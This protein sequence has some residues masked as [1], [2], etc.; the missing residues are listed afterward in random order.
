MA[1]NHRWLSWLAAV[2]PSYHTP[3]RAILAQALWTSALVATGSYRALFTR[4]VYTEWIFFALMAMGLMAAR[5]RSDYRPGVRASGYPVVPLLFA[6]VST[7]IALDRLLSD[8]LDG[9]IGLA[10]VVSGLPF[11]YW[12][13]R[14]RMSASS[15][16]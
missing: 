8:P 4:V 1:S 13:G 14:T 9:L 12:G 3:H 10:L 16:T 11:Y 2:H 6:V 15:I 5:R 7:A